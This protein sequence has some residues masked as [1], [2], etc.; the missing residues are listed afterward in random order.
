MSKRIIQPDDLID[1]RQEIDNL[2]DC[3][4]KNYTVFQEAINSL[5]D[6]I[7]KLENVMYKNDSEYLAKLV[8][9]SSRL[10]ALER[11]KII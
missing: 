11:K 1:L 4:Q 2:K 8:E 3:H 9:L 10:D 6:R 7:D 5:V